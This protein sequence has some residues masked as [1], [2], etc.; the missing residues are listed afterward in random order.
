MKKLIA[1]AVVAVI[2]IGALLMTGCSTIDATKMP[3]TLLVADKFGDQGICDAAKVGADSL[4]NDFA[5]DMKPYVECGGSDL[6]GKI[7]T[8]AEESTIIIC[9]GDAFTD[10]SMAEDYPD[11]RFIW[12]GKDVTP[13]AKNAVNVICEDKD[14]T[15]AVYSTLAKYIDGKTEQWGTTWTFNAESDTIETH[16]MT[17]AETTEEPSET[18]E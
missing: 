13:V 4:I 3:V 6:S 15:A 14:V 5:I 8:A 9:V 11:S 16:V 12:I 17:E 10:R 18:K 7:K 2:M 1:L